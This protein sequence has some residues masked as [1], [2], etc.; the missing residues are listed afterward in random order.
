[1]YE[2]YYP[3]PS[4]DPPEPEDMPRCPVCGGELYI[5]GWLFNVFTCEECGSV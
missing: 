2:R 4:L 5:T 1:M 3:E